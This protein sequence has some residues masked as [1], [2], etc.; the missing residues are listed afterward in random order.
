[1]LSPPFRTQFESSNV[2]VLIALSRGTWS[3]KFCGADEKLK[4]VTTRDQCFKCHLLH[5]IRR[6]NAT[7]TPSV[8]RDDIQRFERNRSIL[9]AQEKADEV[10]VRKAIDLEHEKWS[11]SACRRIPGRSQAGGAETH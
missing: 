8:L 10:S 3:V 4:P 6:S 5:I 1:M 11:L 9:T 7:Q 2:N